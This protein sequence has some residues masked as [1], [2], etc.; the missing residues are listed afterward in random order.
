MNH[1]PLK[2][3]ESDDHVGYGDNSDK[4]S[5]YIKIQCKFRKMLIV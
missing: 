5:Q 1:F 4:V 2:Y 3:R